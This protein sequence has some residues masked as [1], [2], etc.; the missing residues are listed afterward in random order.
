MPHIF[1]YSPYKLYYS[2][3]S[4]QSNDHETDSVLQIGFTGL[5]INYL[6]QKQKIWGSSHI[7]LP[8]ISVVGY[9]RL[10]KKKCMSLC[11]CSDNTVEPDSSDGK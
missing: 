8:E 3:K 7:L 9:F 10:S 1:V 6:F 2:N 11:L 4:K 5:Q